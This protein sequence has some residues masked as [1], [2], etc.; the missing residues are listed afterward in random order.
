MIIIIKTPNKNRILIKAASM[1]LLVGMFW[2]YYN[3]MSHKFQEQNQQL[4]SKLHL[5]KVTKRVDRSRKIEDT[6]YKESVKI[7]KLL[8]QKNVKSIKVVADKLLIICNYNTDIEPL[9]VR[10]GAYSMVRT[11][12]T[13]IKIG[14]D[15]KMIVENKYES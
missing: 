10:Y 6:I 3:H 11:T 15:L 4:A 2:L 1:L 14:I 8:Q 7:V 13:S 9:L 5:A 12:M